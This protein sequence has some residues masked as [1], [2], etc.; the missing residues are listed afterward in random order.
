MLCNA[1]HCFGLMFFLLGTLKN[2]KLAN[3]TYTSEIWIDLRL[4]ECNSET[5]RD[6]KRLVQTHV[7]NIYSNFDL[8]RQ[9]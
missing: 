7:K 5:M 8:Q 2:I 3:A 6:E 9:F 4:Y 1:A